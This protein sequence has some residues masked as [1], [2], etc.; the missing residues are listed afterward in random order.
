KA[1]DGLGPLPAPD[2]DRCPCQG[3]LAFP[4]DAW[5]EHARGV[6]GRPGAGPALS[7]CRAGE[8][9]RPPDPDHQRLERVDGRLLPGAGHLP[10]N[11]LSGGDQDRLWRADALPL[12]DRCETGLFLASAG[13]FLLTN[14]SICLTINQSLRFGFTT[15]RR[16]GRKGGENRIE[17]SNP[18]ASRKRSAF[19]AIP[20]P[21]SPDLPDTMLS[22]QRRKI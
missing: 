19:P 22:F 7:G 6:P 15:R 16:G 17:A 10:W 21:S 8:T 3:R 4:A 5:R 18:N 11:G 2:P 13:K 14:R 9:G 12:S 20:N 1:Y